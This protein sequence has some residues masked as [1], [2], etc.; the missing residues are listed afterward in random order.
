MP[1]IEPR[2]AG[3]AVPF[4]IGRSQSRYEPRLVLPSIGELVMT[5]IS[6]IDCGLF[7]T[8]PDGTW[9]GRSEKRF[10]PDVQELGVA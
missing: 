3:G 7:A 9:I 2:Y 10:P 5:W 8:H 4:V 1:S 6:Y